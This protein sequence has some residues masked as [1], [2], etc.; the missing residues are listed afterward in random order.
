LGDGNSKKRLLFVPELEFADQCRDD[1]SHLSREISPRNGGR[2]GP[3][4]G[5][6]K[7]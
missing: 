3:W 6:T 1:M 4:P 2:N 7:V 5:I